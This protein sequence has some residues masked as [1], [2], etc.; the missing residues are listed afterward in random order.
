MAFATALPSDALGGLVYGSLRRFVNVHGSFTRIPGRSSG[1]ADRAV[2]DEPRRLP[3]PHKSRSTSCSQ[4]APAETATTS[5]RWLDVLKHK[6]LPTREVTTAVPRAHQA[7]PLRPACC[8]WRGAF[9]LPTTAFPA[10]RRDRSR[11]PVLRRR[12]HLCR[13]SAKKIAFRKTRDASWTVPRLHLE[14]C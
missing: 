9:V 6:P 10:N 13:P 1:L 12:K 3:L 14:F 4:A 7:G 11:A 2:M 5:A 8:S